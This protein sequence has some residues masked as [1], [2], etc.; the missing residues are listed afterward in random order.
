MQPFEQSSRIAAWLGQ[1]RTCPGHVPD[2]PTCPH[3]DGDTT[4]LRDTDTP[5]PL[6]SRVPGVSLGLSHYRNS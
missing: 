2:V 5:T 3:I 4:I 6:E 1:S